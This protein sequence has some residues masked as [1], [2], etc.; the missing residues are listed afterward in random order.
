LQNVKSIL[1]FRIGVLKLKRAKD[2]KLKH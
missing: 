2:W 1:L